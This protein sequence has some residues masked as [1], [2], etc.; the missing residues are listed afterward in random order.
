MNQNSGHRISPDLLSV[1]AQRT[2]EK[3]NGISIIH[4]A[5]KQ[6]S[7]IGR[8]LLYE[9]TDK[10]TILF[11][12]GGKTPAGL[13]SALAK[14][15]RL[16]IG[17]AAM[18]DERYGKPHHKQSN[19]L[20]IEQ[21]GLSEY[22]AKSNIPFY[23]ILAEEGD[24]E[25]TARRYNQTVRRLFSDFAKSAAILGI[26]EDGH[27]AGIAPNRRGFVNRLFASEQG[28]LLVSYFEDPQPMSVRGNA[29][30]PFGFGKRIT[31]TIR[32]LSEIDVLLVLVFGEKKKAALL[33][34]FEE[35]PVEQVPARF[36]KYKEIA[37]KTILITDQ[38]A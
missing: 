14:E 32:G 1:L 13:Y 17:A 38:R 15:R 4:A 9:I 12:S 11:L 3:K 18:A 5:E 33:K 30:P 27:I 16:E 24:I 20:M 22:F 23:R 28:D 35:G 7:D 26:G 8:E 21:S 37:A 6:G 36:I 25:N 10:D 29:A 19:E 31:M 34:L 2:R